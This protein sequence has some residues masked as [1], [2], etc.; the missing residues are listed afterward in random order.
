[1]GMAQALGPDTLFTA[2]TGSAIFSLEICKMEALM[3]AFQRS[4]SVHIKE[5]TD[6]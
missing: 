5:E 3:Q 2:I 6:H 1:M 4:I